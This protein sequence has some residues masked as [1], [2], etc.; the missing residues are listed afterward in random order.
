MAVLV[1]LLIFS[2]ELWSTVTAMDFAEKIELNEKDLDGKEGGEEKEIEQD[3]DKWN[4][5]EIE[6]HFHSLSAVHKDSR[7]YN[8]HPAEGIFIEIIAPPP[9]L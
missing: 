2:A 7:G 9:E 1:V 6:L 3:L 4:R 5:K 8:N